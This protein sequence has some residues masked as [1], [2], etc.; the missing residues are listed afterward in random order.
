MQATDG[1]STL[2]HLPCILAKVVVYQHRA[3]WLGRDIVESQR[4]GRDVCRGNSTQNHALSGCPR[5][6]RLFQRCLLPLMTSDVLPTLLEH[7]FFFLFWEGEIFITR[8][9]DNNLK[10]MCCSTGVQ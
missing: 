4:L 5:L 1:P 8:S 7:V 9:N 6:V 3:Q 10:E 2:A